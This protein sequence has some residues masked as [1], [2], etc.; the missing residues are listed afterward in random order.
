AGLRRSVT[1]RSFSAADRGHLHHCLLRAGL[2]HPHT[3]L[4]ITA[5]CGLA[6]AGAVGSAQLRTDEPALLA[7]APVAILL[8]APRLFG[9]TEL[10]LIAQSTGA[11][12][13]KLFGARRE[14]LQRVVRFQG[15]AGCDALWAR[16]TA[17]VRPLNLRSLVLDVNSPDLC[18]D[19]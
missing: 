3:L 7:A 11:S 12:A 10:A 5:L 8:V 18:E 9:H 14:G 4:L 17:C 13:G 15:S 2:S 1:G 6:G 16:L 19:Y